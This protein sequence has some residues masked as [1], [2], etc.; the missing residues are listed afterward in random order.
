LASQGGVCTIVNSSCC[1]YVDNNGKVTGDLQTIWKKTK[2]LHQ[3][4]QDNTSWGFHESWDK[5]TS[6]LPNLIWL[7]QLLAALIG[8]ILLFCVLSVMMK[9][10]F[11]CCFNTGYSY[12]EWKKNRLRQELESNKYFREL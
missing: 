6:W 3:V 4:A 12:S 11:Y 2:I 5:L 8:I 9:C 1:T 7:K 10:A